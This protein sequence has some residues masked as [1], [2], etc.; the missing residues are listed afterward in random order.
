MEEAPEVSVKFFYNS[1]VV[2]GNIISMESVCYVE[3]YFLTVCSHSKEDW[4]NV[5]GRKVMVSVSKKMFKESIY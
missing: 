3:V 5:V 4:T 2:S 1:A